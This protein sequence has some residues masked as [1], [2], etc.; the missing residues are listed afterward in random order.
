MKRAGMFEGGTMLHSA[1]ML[2][3]RLVIVAALLGLASLSGAC[4]AVPSPSSQPD[5]A[6][7][8]APRT[9]EFSTT[10]IPADKLVAPEVAE[11]AAQSDCPGLDSTL[12]RVVASPDP[13]EQAR[14]SLLTVKD[15]K[16][17]VV[18]VLSQEEDTA[19]L[20]DYD[21]EIGSQS[22]TQV[23]AFVPPDRLC[24]LAN[25]DEVLTISPAA[26]AVP[27]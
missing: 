14:Q 16:I 4:V 20:Q 27:Q 11:P 6:P 9:P 17:Q 21:V 23:Q 5:A 24:D 26:Q 7:Q 25:T 15:G 22:G 10:Q 1:R 3:S 13:L 8:D 19:F 18:L 12:A 2:P